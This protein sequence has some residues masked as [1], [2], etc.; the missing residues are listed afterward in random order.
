MDKI[1]KNPSDGDIFAIPLYLPSYHKWRET[2]D[3]FIDY[4]KYKFNND[5]VYAFGRIIESY[6]N[7]NAYIMEIFRYAG[8]IPDCPEL[9]KKSGRMFKPVIAGG[10]FYRGRWRILFE[11]SDYDKWQDSDYENI[12]F[13]YGSDI[14]KGGKKIHITPQQHKE[15]W[16]SGDI[17]RPVIMGSVQIECD[18]RSMLAEW[19]VELN[20]EQLVEERRAGYPQPRDADKKLKETILPFRWIADNGKY[21]LTIEAGVFNTESFAKL[22]M[23]GNGYDLEQIATAYMEENMPL[24]KGKLTFDC[25]ADTFSV[26]ASSKKELKEFAV[27]FHQ[28]CE[29]NR[30]I[31][32]HQ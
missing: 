28:F 22:G 11:D 20:Y 18:I 12:S 1:K 16:E 23:I 2:Y 8:K 6:D 24:L 19:G 31:I 30:Y 10:M 13:L 9:I 15:L 21:T 29:D 5:D 25:E 4:K 7:K 17:A 3:E 14:W 27:G 26:K 32:F